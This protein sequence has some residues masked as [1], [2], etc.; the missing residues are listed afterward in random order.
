[1]FDTMGTY[2]KD[3]LIPFICNPSIID[4]EKSPDAINFIALKEKFEK[5]NNNYFDLVDEIGNIQNEIDSIDKKSPE[6]L[7]KSVEI[8]NKSVDFT[9]LAKQRGQINLK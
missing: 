5:T 2:I 4:D 7:K 3:E 8:A 9:I 1:M 6:Y